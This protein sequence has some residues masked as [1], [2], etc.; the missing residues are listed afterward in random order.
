MNSLNFVEEKDAFNSPVITVKRNVEL[1][2]SKF[3]KI[4]IF[5]TRP[6]LK[7]DLDKICKDFIKSLPWKYYS[8]IFSFIIDITDKK[9]VLGYCL[10][11]YFF[12]LFLVLNAINLSK[13]AIVFVVLILQLENCQTLY[14]SSKR[15][16][17]R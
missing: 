8:N 5:M 4:T 12:L 11:G 13:V 16:V 10:H 2:I 6:S 7:Y 9:N 1:D 15:F 17:S 14:F 3:T